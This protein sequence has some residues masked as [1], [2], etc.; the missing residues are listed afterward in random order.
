MKLFSMFNA[1]VYICILVFMKTGCN[2]V[3]GCKSKSDP[4]ISDWQDV[5]FMC[6]TYNNGHDFIMLF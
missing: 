6:F 1:F 3:C 5:R 2:G 4:N